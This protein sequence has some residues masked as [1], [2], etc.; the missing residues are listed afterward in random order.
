MIHP[1]INLAG[2]IAY[3]PDGEEVPWRF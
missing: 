1:A 3:K 2:E